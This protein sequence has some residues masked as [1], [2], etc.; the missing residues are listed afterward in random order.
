MTGFHMVIT[1]S[2]CAK[3]YIQNLIAAGYAPDRVVVVKRDAGVLSEEK[4]RLTLNSTTAQKLIRKE[5]G[6]DAVFDE[7]QAIEVTLDTYSIPYVSV[8][9]EDTLN[10]KSA[11]L[12]LSSL[13]V[14]CEGVV[15]ACLKILPNAIHI[16]PGAYPKYDGKTPYYYQ[17]LLEQSL[18]CVVMQSHSTPIFTLNFKPPSGFQ[19]LDLVIDPLMRA[20]TLVA[21][22]KQGCPIDPLPC[23]VAELNEFDDIHAVLMHLAIVQLRQSEGG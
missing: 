7:K 18:S 1:E 21:W 6:F 9:A 3:A 13:P 4:K 8:L 10:F 14:L 2:M 20:Q 11:L 19:Q 22:M 12:S 17:L 5:N 16:H 15:D 23:N